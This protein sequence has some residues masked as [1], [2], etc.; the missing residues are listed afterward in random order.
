MAPLGDGPTIIYFCPPHISF[1][2]AVTLQPVR[3][4]FIPLTRI[5]ISFFWES[6]AKSKAMS[7]AYKKMFEARQTFKPVR[8]YG[9]PDGNSDIF[10]GII[11]NN[12]FIFERDICADLI[13][14]GYKFR[15]TLQQKGTLER[16]IRVLEKLPE[17]DEDEER[18]Q[19]CYEELETVK[20]NH[21]QNEQKM[22]ADESMI[23]PGPLKRD[24]DAMRQDP[25]WYLRKELIEDCFGRGGCCARGCDCCRNRAS[26]SYKR[27]VGHCTTDCG[28]CASE[29]GFEYTAGEKQE[30]VEQL[31]KMLRSRNPSYIVKMA[32]AYFA[33]PLE[34][35]VLEQVQKKKLQKK[36]VWWKQLL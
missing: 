6:T 4:A 31:D 13:I 19:L 30:T 10:W 35:K 11:Y 5:K 36:K 28:C 24:Y 2:L 27:G 12:D 21:S 18:L 20:R 32:E 16:K 15:Q 33:K 23:P 22:F 1:L 26:A 8:R 29:R 3:K 34:Q 7:P 17:N 14:A 9:Q 25:A